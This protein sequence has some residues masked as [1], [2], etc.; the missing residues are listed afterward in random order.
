MLVNLNSVVFLCCLSVTLIAAQVTAEIESAM[1]ADA[2][3]LPDFIR[4]QAC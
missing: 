3:E 1:S 2:F 4:K